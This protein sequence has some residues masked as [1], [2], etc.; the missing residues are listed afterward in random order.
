MIPVQL[1]HKFE[2]IHNLPM[3]CYMG[4]SLRYMRVLISSKSQPYKMKL[5]NKLC[6]LMTN[7]CHRFYRA[8]RVS[9]TK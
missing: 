8:L 7:V 2:M 9:R 6:H 1:T 4:L 5:H 3:L